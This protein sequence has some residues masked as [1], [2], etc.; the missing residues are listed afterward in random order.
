MSTRFNSISRLSF[1]SKQ[2][3][4]HRLSCLIAGLF[5]LLPIVGDARITSPEKAHQS[6]Q[7][8]QTVQSAQAQPKT[9]NSEVV[10]S[11]AYHG[12]TITG[13]FVTIASDDKR[14]NLWDADGEHLA[15][16]KGDDVELGPQGVLVTHNKAANSFWLWDNRGNELA[17]FQGQFA[18][19]TS[20]GSLVSYD[21]AT[22][23]S[24]L[25]TVDGY[26]A[27]LEGIFLQHSSSGDWLVT[28]SSTQ[29][30]I[31]PDISN[32]TIML[33]DVNGNQQARFEGA[34][35]H[36][37]EISPDQQHLAIYS[38][39]N[40]SP[41]EGPF[42]HLWD[43]TSEQ[44]IASFEGTFLTFVGDQTLAVYTYTDGLSHLLNFDGQ[45]LAS[46][47]GRFGAVISENI[48]VTSEV[49][50][51]GAR[52]RT[53]TRT[54]LWD[55]QGQ[56]IALLEDEMLRKI[57]PD[58]KIVS[59]TVSN[60][61][62]RSFNLWNSDGTHEATLGSGNFVALTPDG[63]HLVTSKHHQSSLW[64]FHGQ[65]LAVFTGRL[66]LTERLESFTQDG[67]LVTYNSSNDRTHLWVI[68][69]F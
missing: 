46:F 68:D 19:V 59:S 1:L 15:S 16:L 7:P 27:S 49:P 20:H 21:A 10:V 55:T 65:R 9:D 42:T 4:P 2:R 5:V 41:K 44:K 17:S 13:Q 6:I 64:N 25:W 36:H 53:L 8:H 31:Y 51:L 33:W 18:G 22:D 29:T 28:Q 54:R 14:I 45:E 67:R 32:D 39:P 62:E 35:Y 3:L 47:Q 66:V 24:H 52:R 34:A 12:S 26:Q 48:V 11:G 56:E 43:L 63:Q 50:E 40:Y 60:Q 38:S 58:G 23:T 69:N 57:V 30:S 37:V 61:S